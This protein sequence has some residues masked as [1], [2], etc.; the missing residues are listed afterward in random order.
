VLDTCAVDGLCAN[1]CPVDINTGDLVKRLRN[2][3]HSPFANKLGLLAAKNFA[4]LEVFVKLGLA[5]RLHKVFPNSI[6][7]RVDHPPAV[8][9][10][11]D[12][13]YSFI[14]FPSCVS[15]FMGTTNGKSVIESFISVT[16]KAGFSV[17]IPK[18]IKGSC[19]GQIFSSKGLA[20]AYRY[21]ANDFIERLW[22]ITHDGQVPIVT[23]V[24]SC[25]Y[26]LRNLRSALSDTNKQRYDLI[27]MYD[28]VEFLHD[29]V[30]PVAKNITRKGSI[31]LHPVCSLEKMGTLQKFVAIAHFF[32]DRVT[33][34]QRAG[35][36]GMAGDRGFLF[37]ELT[38]SATAPEA[39]EVKMIK[40]DGYYSSTKTCEIAISAAVNADYESII[41]LADECMA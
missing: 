10:T 39:E 34:P 37:P 2:E 5:L 24:S 40:Y 28:S 15:R 30:L 19:C 25:A 41:H 4:L 13:S 17:I 11:A 16:K 38:A 26:T 23:D 32:A 36:C 20:N 35:C 29:H 1:A 14:Y 7:R 3:N 18:N 33:V 9:K 27:R 12:I 8:P 21:K 22:P 6:L 31:V